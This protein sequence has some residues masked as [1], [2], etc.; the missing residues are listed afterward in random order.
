VVCSTCT[1]VHQPRERLDGGEQL[2]VGGDQ[3]S[4]HG[5]QLG[6]LGEHRQTERHLAGDLGGVGVDPGRGGSV[7]ALALRARRRRRGVARGGG[8]AVVGGVVLRRQGRA[9]DPMC[10]AGAGAGD[11]RGAAGHDTDGTTPV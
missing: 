5:G 1:G 7:A 9:D 11:G 6:Q 4:E 10:P 2:L 3:R 8:G